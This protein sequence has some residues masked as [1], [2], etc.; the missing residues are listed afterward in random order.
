MENPC[1]LEI[2]VLVVLHLNKTQLQERLL[3]LHWPPAYLLKKQWQ[4]LLLLLEFLH[5]QV[6]SEEIRCQ[7]HLEVMSSQE[8][9]LALEAQE[10]LAL[11]AQEILV[12]AEDLVILILVQE[13]IKDPLELFLHQVLFNHLVLFNNQEL[14]FQLKWVL[15]QLHQ[16][17]LH[18]LLARV[19]LVM[20]EVVFME[21]QVGL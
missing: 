12:L 21:V 15:L 6:V 9:L 1:H 19:F 20:T 13:V 7:Q 17:L 16:L 11:E 18:P 2:L 5:H 8:V 4:K 10:T 3:K 14:I